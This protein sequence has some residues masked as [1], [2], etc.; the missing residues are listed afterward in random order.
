MLELLVKIL[1]S[2]SNITGGRGDQY[3]LPLPSCLSHLPCPPSL[4]PPPTPHSLRGMG[5]HGAGRGQQRGVECRGRAAQEAHHTTCHLPGAALMPFLMPSPSPPPSS[6][7]PPSAPPIRDMHEMPL[8]FTCSR[9]WPLPIGLL[10]Q[11]LP[12]QPSLPSQPAHTHAFHPSTPLPTH[13]LA[14]SPAAPFP[15]SPPF[16]FPIPAAATA[17]FPS[18]ASPI[19]FL[20]LSPHTPAITPSLPAPATAAT[21]GAGGAAGGQAGRAAGGAMGAADWADGAVG[22]AHMGGAFMEAGCFTL[23]HAHEELQPVGME[24]GPPWQQGGGGEEV[25]WSSTEVPLLATFNH[26]RRQHSVWHLR[27]L[28][29][30]FLH[31]SPVAT[32]AAELDPLLAG[33]SP[34]SPATAAAAG[35]AGGVRAGGQEGVAA[36]RGGGVGGDAGMVGDLRLQAGRG[37][38]GGSVGS[39]G[40]RGRGGVTGVA[41]TAKLSRFAGG[42]GDGLP[43]GGVG[44]RAAAGQEGTLRQSMEG[45]AR[46]GGDIRYYPLDTRGAAIGGTSEE[47]AT[48]QPKE[49]ATR[50]EDEA[51]APYQGPELLPVASDT[52]TFSDSD[53]VR[54]T[55][56]DVLRAAAVQVLATNVSGAR[57]RTPR[58]NG[59]RLAREAIPYA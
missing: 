41:A 55:S 37:D 20:A 56:L 54:G 36:G 18:P 40:R 8:P 27:Y 4:P 9:L 6:S 39:G 2:N 44:V 22:G 1:R 46:G 50:G 30:R 35:R 49:V 24:G 7:P 14:P 17:P 28:P 21:A 58:T 38:G 19:P 31:Q 42:G 43:A 57:D 32:S 26:A 45:Q 16:A 10:L 47:V 3:F 52:R 33:L 12:S 34:E 13:P 51:S 11:P 5:S 15:P 59:G 48:S 23:S 29:H 53:G 25:L